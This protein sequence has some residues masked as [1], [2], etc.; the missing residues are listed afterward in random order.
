MS[1]C[2]FEVTSPDLRPDDIGPV[3]GLGSPG[4]RFP[5]PHPHG[6]E[7]QL[8]LLREG[9]TGPDQRRQGPAHRQQGQ[10]GNGLSPALAAVSTFFGKEYILTVL[11]SMLQTPPAGNKTQYEE[12]DIPVALLS[13]SDMLDIS[14]VRDQ[15]WLRLSSGFAYYL[16]EHATLF[17]NSTTVCSPLILDELIHT[18]LIFV[19]AHSRYFASI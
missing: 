11:F 6:D 18:P 8:H 13:Y 17:P 3:L 5:E 15:A 2:V 12:I 16:K 10:T 19:R 14:K 1:C 7:R 4:G 9:P